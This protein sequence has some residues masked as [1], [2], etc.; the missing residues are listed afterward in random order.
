[1][2]TEVSFLTVPFCSFPLRV[3][4]EN[5]HLSLEW[6]A[7]MRSSISVIPQIQIPPKSSSTSKNKSKSVILECPES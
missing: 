7:D 6:F 4:I 3:P 2:F 1:M 5:E